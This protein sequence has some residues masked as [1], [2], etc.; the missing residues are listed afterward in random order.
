[1]TLTSW[2][3]VV[4]SA[5]ALKSETE[6]RGEPE[7]L[8]MGTALAILSLVGVESLA[9]DPTVFDVPGLVRP[10]R[11]A[12][13]TAVCAIEG[14]LRWRL[15]PYKIPSIDSARAELGDGKMLHRRVGCRAR[16]EEG[17]DAEIGTGGNIGGRA[18][19]L[20]AF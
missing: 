10:E 6:L 1:M 4:L 18:I 9:F 7:T 16:G 15:C 14:E 11:G 2:K 3:L 8:I 19:S 20:E 17:A 12:D 13:R 5:R